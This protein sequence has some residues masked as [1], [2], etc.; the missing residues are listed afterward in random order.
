MLEEEGALVVQG[1]PLQEEVEE[2]E[3]LGISL[4]ALAGSSA[5]RTMRLIGKVG[6]QEVIVLIDTGSTHSFVDPNV[7]R[8][9]YL[10]ADGEGQLT[11]M[12][13]D[14]ATLSCQG[15]CK[16]VSILLQGCSFNSTLYL[17]PLR[18]CDMVLGVDWLRILGPILWDFTGLTMRFTYLNR[19]VQLQGLTLSPDLLDARDTIPKSTGADCKGLWVQLMVVTR[20][21]NK[22]LLHPAVQELLGKYTVLF[23]DPE[24][25]PPIRS[26]DH[27]ISLQEGAKPTCVR[28]YRYPYH[29]KEK[30]EKLV[31][32]MLS[33]VVIRPSQSPYSSPVLL[34][35]KVD[36]SWRMCVDYRALNRDTIKDKYPVPNIDELLDELHEAIIF[37]KL[38]LRS[39]YHQIRMRPEDITKTVFRTHEGHYEFLVMPFG[40]TN[41]PSTFQG[42]MNE[43]F[44]PYLRKFV[45]VFFD[46]I[47]VY[48][49]NIMEYLKHLKLVLEALKQ[50]QLY[51]KMSKCSF[52]SLEVDYLGHLISEEGVKA[53]PTKIEAIINW[54]NPRTPKALRG[55]L[56]LTGYY[57][58]FVK[59]YGGIAAPLTA[60]IKKNS[61]GWNDQAKEAFKNLKK[62]DVNSTG[63]R[64]S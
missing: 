61:F 3:L 7:A 30:I 59:G 45:L 9:A 39:G 42:L 25:L 57:R 14:G 54:P 16:A 4:H 50:H 2:G 1:E 53:D 52:G 60:F 21:P 64:S 47:L 18:G 38:D 27:K 34:V 19:E 35:R 33:S 5:P 10:S 63:S 13:A 62:N 24:G 15:H 31:R 40:L 11:V 36:G 26:Y 43:V 29:Q 46:D 8:K 51:A 56:G 37:S 41:A 22:A 12:V 32:E 28:P 48:S 23:K 58:K 44:R 6:S 20:Q 49:K 55:F 17:L